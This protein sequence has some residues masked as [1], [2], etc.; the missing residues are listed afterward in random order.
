MELYP[1][2]FSSLC[3]GERDLPEVSRRE[4]D[5]LI[6]EEDE[7]ILLEERERRARLAPDGQRPGTGR[8]G[9]DC[10]PISSLLRPEPLSS[11]C[12]V[13]GGA[14]GSGG[15]YRS[16]PALTSSCRTVRAGPP[17]PGR[18]PVPAG[19]ASFLLPIFPSGRKG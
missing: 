12:R 9:P 7:A 13:Q 3:Q 14:P 5:L 10:A 4:L 1:L 15:G 8:L 18:G 11:L 17:G 2:P 19:V 16:T 6:A